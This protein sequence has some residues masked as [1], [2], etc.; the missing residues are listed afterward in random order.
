MKEIWEKEENDSKWMNL[1]FNSQSRRRFSSCRNDE[2][3][4]GRKKR[5]IEQDGRRH[6]EGQT[7][8]FRLVQGVTSLAS[9]T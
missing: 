1:S 4:M 9:F 5:V 6:Y 2:R 7:E 3:N 8:I